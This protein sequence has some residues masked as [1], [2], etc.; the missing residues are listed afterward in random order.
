MTEGGGIN[1]NGTVPFKG[2]A[3]GNSGVEGAALAV[4]LAMGAGFMVL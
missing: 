4:V 3:A 1:L 2:G